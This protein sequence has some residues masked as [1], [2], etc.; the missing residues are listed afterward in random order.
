MFW[1]TGFFFCFLVY[2]HQHNTFS[3]NFSGRWY[4]DIFRYN[5][6]ENDFLINFYPGME[7]VNQNKHYLAFW[8]YLPDCA[9][10]FFCQYWT[11]K[12][13]SNAWLLQNCCC[14][15][16]CP[17]FCQN[18]LWCYDFIMVSK[19]TVFLKVIYVVLYT[20]NSFPLVYIHTVLWMLRVPHR[21]IC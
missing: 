9:L 3:Q 19:Y 10:D 13:H 8:R 4:V 5:K 14:C 11:M 17:Y 6:Y 2:H 16:Y 7:S 12:C 20:S 21:H 15:S 18:I 1:N